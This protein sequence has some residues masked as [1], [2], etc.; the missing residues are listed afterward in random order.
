MFVISG[1]ELVVVAAAGVGATQILIM[2]KNAIAVS[3]AVTALRETEVQKI[4]LVSHQHTTPQVRRLL[5]VEKVRKCKFTNANKIILI[6]KSKRD[7]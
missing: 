4:S 1:E 5:Q 7:F 2:K 6:L 3:V